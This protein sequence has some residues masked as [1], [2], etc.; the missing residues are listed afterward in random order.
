MAVTPKSILR[1]YFETG[2]HPTQEEFWELI[3]SYFH[4]SDE[5]ELPGGKRVAIKNAGQ[6]VFDILNSLAGEVS[7]GVGTEAR[8]KFAMVFA[9]DSKPMQLPMII[10]D[11]LPA[12]VDSEQ[13]MIYYVYDRGK[14]AHFYSGQWILIGNGELPQFTDVVPADTTADCYF[15][16]VQ[17][18]QTIRIFGQKQ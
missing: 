2:D 3:D 18:G 16:V 6:Y 4:L 14:I 9:G 12:P 11:D 1:T 7:V 17:G 8:A 13:G 10:Y 15:D 5:N